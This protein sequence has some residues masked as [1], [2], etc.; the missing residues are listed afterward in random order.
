MP[1]RM[2]RTRVS[3]FL[4]LTVNVEWFP[5]PKSCAE[6]S[7]IERENACAIMSHVA[8]MT[9]ERACFAAKIENSPYQAKTVFVERLHW[10]KKPF[11]WLTILEQNDAA[12]TRLQLIRT[13]LSS[14]PINHSSS[15]SQAALRLDRM[16]V[17]YNVYGKLWNLP[18]KRTKRR[19]SGRRYIAPR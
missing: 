10:S 15:L 5:S 17:W 9:L 1:T 8:Q 14:C 3:V 4:Q 16:I 19:Q 13:A 6:K 7:C 18:S 12:Q 2:T 11:C